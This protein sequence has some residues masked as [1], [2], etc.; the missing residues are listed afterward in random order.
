MKMIMSAMT[1]RKIK[2]YLRHIKSLKGDY[3]G[4]ANHSDSQTNS[5]YFQNEVFVVRNFFGKQFK[6][7]LS[8]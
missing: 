5:L 3:Q 4:Y 2:K 1:T 6:F 7:L 8:Q